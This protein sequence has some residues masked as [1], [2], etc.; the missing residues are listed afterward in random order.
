MT[1][2]VSFP[3][4]R[5][6]NNIEPG[7]F[8]VFIYCLSYFLCKIKKSLSDQMKKSNDKTVMD[9]NPKMNEIIV[10]SSLSVAITPMKSSRTKNRKIGH[11]GKFVNFGSFFLKKK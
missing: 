7:L 2:H 3:K 11:T 1:K 8:Y 5:Y 4:P 6:S 9:K 10:I